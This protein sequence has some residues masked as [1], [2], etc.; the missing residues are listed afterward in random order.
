MY[1]GLDIGHLLT[2]QLGPSFRQAPQ[3]G[4]AMSDMQLLAFWNVQLMWGGGPEVI[5]IAGTAVSLHCRTHV[6]LP[7][8]GVAMASL[9]PVKWE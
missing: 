1:L 5:T 9:Q 8:L 2:Q 4:E 7:R 3:G 6:F